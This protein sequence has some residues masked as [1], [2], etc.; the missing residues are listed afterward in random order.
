[1]TKQRCFRVKFPATWGFLCRIRGFIYRSILFMLAGVLL[2]ACG[3][4]QPENHAQG[5]TSPVFTK[6]SPA[7]L[8]TLEER[9][10]PTMPVSTEELKI[11]IIY[12]NN[13]Y[14]PRLDT[15]WGFSALVEYRGLTLLFDTGGDGRILLD[16]MRVLEID[17]VH[18]QSVV[19]SHAHGDHTGGLSALLENSDQPPVYLLPS[20]ADSYK[21]Q[22]ESVTQV[23]EST[24]GQVIADGILTT[25][26]IG[27]SIPEQALMIQTRRGLVIITGCAHPGVTRIIERAMELTREPVY[28][29]LGGFHLGEKSKSEVSTI[30]ADFRRLEVQYVAPCHCTGERAIAMFADEFNQAF[31]QA[32]AGKIIAINTKG[33]IHENANH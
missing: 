16:N 6:T 29:V 12:D 15:A 27:G 13:L 4:A 28:L 8:P 20:F 1:M 14:D 22:L 30:L 5:L 2:Y 19:L 26:E 11:T 18:I 10:L 24:P 32:G 3:Q 33:E 17:P 21:Q 7:T 23:Y 25:G 31:I 9:E